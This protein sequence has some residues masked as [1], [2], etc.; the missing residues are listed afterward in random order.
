MPE[1]VR[2]QQITVRVKRGVTPMVR[3]YS[4]QHL[5]GQTGN[6]YQSP[7]AVKR[8]TL[9]ELLVVIGI[10]AILASLLLPALQ[11]ARQ[12]AYDTSCK[13]HLDQIMLAATIYHDD[14]DGM[15][16]EISS[17]LFVE[18]YNKILE[19]EKDYWLCPAGDDN[20]SSVGTPNGIV[21]HY[22]VNHYHYGIGGTEMDSYLDTLSGINMSSVASPSTAIYLADADPTSSPHNIGGAQDGYSDASHWPLTSLMESRHNGAYNVGMLDSSVRSFRD[23]P[24]HKKWGT[25]KK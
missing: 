24:L 5:T 21:L 8:F 15:L 19:T 20:P 18:K 17:P 16:P 3:K 23:K 25:E 11:G 2:G 4:P 12:K 22:G 7:H 14:N 9:V 6:T 13:S 10:I 1:G